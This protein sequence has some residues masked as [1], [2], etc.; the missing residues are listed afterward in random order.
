M[1]KRLREVLSPLVFPVSEGSGKTSSGFIGIKDPVWRPGASEMIL[2]VN[3]RNRIVSLSKTAI[4]TLGYSKK[5]LL[6][7]SIY[8]LL[9]GEDQDQLA[10]ALNYVRRTGT[11]V[12]GSHHSIVRRIDLTLKTAAG[13]HVVC[14][15]RVQ[16]QSKRTIALLFHDLSQSAEDLSGD[17]KID[18]F[19]QASSSAQAP[20]D[21]K[22]QPKEAND[23]YLSSAQLA[24]LS[25]E[26]KT[27]L[28]AILGFTDAM[29]EQTF[30]PLGN[31][32]YQEYVDHI[33][34]S[35]EHLMGLVSAMLEQARIDA[36][37]YRLKPTLGNLTDIASECAAMVHPQIK[38]AGLKLN[39]HLQDVDDSMLDKLAVRQI[40]INLLSNAIKFTSDGNVTLESR[41]EP[42]AHLKIVVRDTGIG[43]NAEQLDML[44]A[45]FTKASTN[46]VRGAAGN[47][48]GLSLAASLA[49]LHGG[50]LML[51]SAPG[52]G[53]CATLTL[54]FVS[55]LA[56]QR[57]ETDFDTENHQWARK[58][59]TSPAIKDV[60]LDG[61]AAQE[62]Y[63]AGRPEA[64]QT[65]MERIDDYR[66]NL[67]SKRDVS[68]A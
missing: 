68:A 5:S 4:K 67:Q 10:S 43:M 3:K 39:T 2:V 38:E 60:P 15:V 1:F 66:R 63:Q 8:R 25:H 14:A 56:P 62:N 45:R 27:P 36:K 41:C 47:G 16:A 64:L 11:L 44:G 6:D 61:S 51:E 37:E 9:S 32:R 18:T 57:E 26:M 22:S 49:D 42:N 29:R 33:Y 7:T 53:L 31:D 35:G 65:Q 55:A 52:E 54:P 20:M 28:N 40:V 34:T 17:M 59:I 50:E 13:K 12:E 24:N 30:G 23:A 46:G 48:L 58:T 19:S 21:T